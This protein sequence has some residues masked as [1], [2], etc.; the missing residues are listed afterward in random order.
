MSKAEKDGQKPEEERGLNDSQLAAITWNRLSR[1]M[2]AHDAW[3]KDALKFE[4]FFAGNQWEEDDLQKLRAAKRPALTIN[5]TKPAVLTIIGEQQSLRAESTFK[6]RNSLADHETA[7]LLAQVSDYIDNDVNFPT[8]E[9]QAFMDA[10]ITDRGYI[11]IRISFDNN[12]NG[13]IAMA[14][15]NPKNIVLDIDCRTHDP[16]QWPGVFDTYWWSLDRIASVYGEE[17]AKR[18]RASSTSALDYVEDSLSLK[19]EDDRIARFEGGTFSSAVKFD[20]NDVKY[21]EEIRIVEHQFFVTRPDALVLID[22]V[23]GD[24]I[25]PRCDLTEE[26]LAPIAAQRGMQLTK[27]PRRR[28]RWHVVARDVVLF[29]GWSPYPFLTKVPVFPTFMRGRPIGVVRDLISPQEQLNKIESQELHVINTTA[30]SGWIYEDGSI[31]NME[32]QEL[33][34][35]GAETGLIIKVRKG[36]GFEPKKI[37]PN[38]IPSGLAHKA[39]KNVEYL[40]RISMVNDAMLGITSPEVSGVAIQAKKKSGITGFVP[41]FSNLE[42][43]RNIIA[44]RKLWLIQNFYTSPRIVRITDYTKPERPDVEVAMNIPDA[45]GNILNNVTVGR[46]DV[47]TSSVPARDNQDETQFAQMIEMRNAG[48][49]LPDDEII[50]RSNLLDKFPLAERIAQM[51]G[52]GEPS[53]QEVQMQQFM[54]QAEMQK[55][56]I[57]LARGEAEVF[58]LQAR[59]QLQMAKAESLK[60]E[61]MASGQDGQPNEKLMEVALERERM[62][63]DYRMHAEKLEATLQQNRETLQAKMQ[64]A[65]MQVGVKKEGMLHQSATNRAKEA[66]KEVDIKRKEQ[67][68]SA[69]LAHKAALQAQATEAKRQLEEKR[70]AA[71][72]EAAKKTAAAVKAKQPSKK[73]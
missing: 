43:A 2:K 49:G 57:E 11:D 17:I 14:A 54:A 72:Q 39:S 46:Y 28:V 10:C 58:E 38:Q 45:T 64:I 8:L 53:E 35:K 18:L 25:D 21:I 56:Q 4:N 37:L 59:A 27:M 30:N 33:E 47:I 7:G 42:V 71:Q 20:N 22:T 16:D 9:S 48:I 26:E 15:D 60:A 73:K 66:N 52:M 41:A 61:A 63:N 40:S 55:V 12:V 50:R 13:D 44:K 65:A 1:S 67:H 70:I 69:V 3:V 31:L 36:A 19:W 23:T 5:L 24:I 6:P 29:Q 68:D 34:T 62:A 51:Q 32:D